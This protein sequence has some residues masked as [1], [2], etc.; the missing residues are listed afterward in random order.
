M[1]IQRL[2]EIACAIQDEAFWAGDEKGFFWA[3]EDI[4][5]YERMMK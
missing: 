1:N 2:W 5:V 3:G 4:R